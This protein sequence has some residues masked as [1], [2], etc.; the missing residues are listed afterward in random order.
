MIAK[1]ILKTKDELHD[2]KDRWGGGNVAG[3][4]GGLGALGLAGGGRGV[5]VCSDAVACGADL[6]AFQKA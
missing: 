1:V 2:F 6:L 3:A 4:V 5:A